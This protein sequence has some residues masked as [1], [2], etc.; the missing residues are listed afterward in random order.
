MIP[1]TETV[2]VSWVV[3]GIIIAAAFLVT[4]NLREV[5]RGPQTLVETAVEFLNNFCKNQFGSWAKY[6]SSYIGTL[7]LFLV[8]ANIIGVLSPVEV[9]CFGLRF[10]PPFIVKPPTRD[11]NVTAPLALVTMGMVLFCGIGKRGIGGWAKHLL[12][13]MPVMLP[14]NI[15]DYGTRLLSLSLRLFGN[16][17]GGFVLMRMIE[18]ILPLALPMIFSLYFDFFDGLVQAAIFVF[19]SCMYLS[20]A[21]TLEDERG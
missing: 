16:I 21:V 18:S 14:F 8:T 11:I 3:M 2:V 20:E 7:F 17:L 10:E 15:M 13:P 4:R 9:N 19:L 12:H 6:F 5:P 1:I